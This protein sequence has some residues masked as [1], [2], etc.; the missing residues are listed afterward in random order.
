MNESRVSRFEVCIWMVRLDQETDF[1]RILSDDERAR[2]ERFY[3]ARD[4]R[5]FTAARGSLRVILGRHLGL[6]PARFVFSYREHGKPFLMDRAV[7]FNVAHS[8]ELALIA[9]SEACEIGVDV[10]QIR[11]RPEMDAIAGRMFPPRELA[12][13]RANPRQQQLPEFFRI[14]T[15]TEARLKV[16]G[17]GLSGLREASAIAWPVQPI[18]TEAG[19][20]AAVAAELDGFDVRLRRFIAAE[21][22]QMPAA[23]A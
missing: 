2:A 15:E 22:A 11:A 17:E 19:Y 6:D 1:A 4:R 8:G 23:R 12:E 13:F 14:W 9:L 3:F 18:A 10:E 5:C 21:F 16:H 7:R 20:A